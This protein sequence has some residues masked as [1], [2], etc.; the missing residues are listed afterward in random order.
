MKVVVFGSTGMVGRAVVARLRSRAD[1]DVVAVSRSTHR[2]SATDSG[3]LD[4]YL[5][6]VELVV[7]CVGTLRSDPSYPTSAFCR[8]ATEVNALWPH[9]LASQTSG[10]RCRV[11]HMSSDA[12][13]GPGSEPGGE[14]ALPGPCE[15]YGWSK[16]LGEV[17]EEHVLNLRF[18]V[19]GPAPDRRPSLWE[20][21]VQQPPGATVPGYS[22]FRWA[23]CTSSQVASLVFD[24]LDGPAFESVRRVGHVH[25]FVPNG[26]ATKRDV[27]QLVSRYL[28]PD[29]SVSSTPEPGPGAR[30]LLSELGAWERIYTGV[31]GWEAAIS[32]AVSDVAVPDS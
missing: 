1:A 31:L 4:E 25:H 13:L 26:L 15:P 12:V 17:C 30:P 11:I 23:G 7:N 22:S 5:E 18:S 24:L 6:G 16:A 8:E 21:L 28:R 9:R 14:G 20:W 32:Q 19:I 29:L 3:D 27:L 2:F 10:R